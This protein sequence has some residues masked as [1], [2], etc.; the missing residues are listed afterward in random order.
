MATTKAPKSVPIQAYVGKNSPYLQFGQDLFVYWLESRFRSRRSGFGQTI[1]CCSAIA[2]FQCKPS[3]SGRFD[4]SYYK[5]DRTLWKPI[6]LLYLLGRP[7]SKEEKRLDEHSIC[8]SRWGV[9][10]PEGGF[11]VLVDISKS[12]PTISISIF[13]RKRL[14]RITSLWEMIGRSWR[15]LAM[16][17]ILLLRDGWRLREGF[18]RYRWARSMTIVGRSRY[19]Y[20]SVSFVRF[21]ICKSDETVD[22]VR[23]RLAKEWHKWDF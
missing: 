20:E 13:I 4:W 22:A 21:A 3:N 18:L 12:I 5:V 16:R 8:L 14:M 7:L 9:L 17:Q 15:T 10:D 6:Q 11:F 19:Y 1:N 2:Q 23:E